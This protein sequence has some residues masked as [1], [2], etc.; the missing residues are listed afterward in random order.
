MA[1]AAFI[2]SFLHSSVFLIGSTA[3]A[4]EHPHGSLLALDVSLE[5]SFL[6]GVATGV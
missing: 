3:P 1:A 6:R 5:M 2:G 4:S